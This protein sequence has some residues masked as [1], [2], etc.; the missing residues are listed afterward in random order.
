MNTT[1]PLPLALTMGEPAGIGP[2][3]C[4][5]TWLERPDNGVPFF[6]IGDV[7]DMEK[8]KRHLGIDVPIVTIENPSEASEISS[9]ALPIIHE[10]LATSSEPGNPV[11]ANS[12]A[13]LRCVK[14]GIKLVTSGDASALVTNPV[15]KE[16]LYASGFP[17]PGITEFLGST[18]DPEVIP[19]MML[20]CPEI[21]AATITTHI[22]LADVASQLN[23]NDII[24]KVKIVENALRSNF[25]VQAPCIAVAGLNPH[26]GKG[27][28]MGDEELKIIEPAIRK[29]QTYNLD[30][31]GPLP[32]D[33]LFHDRA[34]A[35]FDA[36]VCM[37]HDQALIPVK[38]INFWNGVNVTLGLPFIRTS[39]DHGTA[40]DIAGKGI[41]KSTSLSAALN[42]ANEM[43][44][45]KIKLAVDAN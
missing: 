24:S 34:R 42:T 11:K 26:S 23:I 39:P 44:H 28:R 15:Q 31:V 19:V 8:W 17:Y 30:I 14:L 45:N 38:T 43:F 1:Q 18:V 9:V 13:I 7:N 21:R 5:K 40:L 22:G 33:T 3:I 41:A 16:T 10:P 27:G 36:I 12:A 2:E 37:Y 29:L 6:I 35:Q 32:A 25:G 4:L 20:V